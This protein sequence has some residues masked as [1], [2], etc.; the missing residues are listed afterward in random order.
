MP[1]DLSA[2][3]NPA[4]AGNLSRW[5]CKRGGKIEMD[6]RTGKIRIQGTDKPALRVTCEVGHGPLARRFLFLS[7]YRRK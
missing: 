4:I 1:V 6:L 7:S 3:P 2:P 5:G